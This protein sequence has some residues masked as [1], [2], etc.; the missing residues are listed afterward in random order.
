MYGCQFLFDYENRMLT[1]ST[2]HEVTK[3]HIRCTNCG[4]NTNISTNTQGAILRDLTWYDAD[5]AQVRCPKCKNSVLPIVA[6]GPVG[7][8]G[9]LP[10]E[11]TIDRPVKDQVRSE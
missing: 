7:E 3:M 2:L 5:T 10:V 4:A 11:L 8:D 1:G 9:V 6:K